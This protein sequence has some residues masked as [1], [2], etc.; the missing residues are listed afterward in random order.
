MAWGMTRFVVLLGGDLTATSRLASQIQKARIIAADG[1]MAHAEPLGVEPELWVGDF[2]STSED[3]AERHKDV[4]RHA[5]PA[6]KDKT[7]GEIAVDEA[8]KLGAREIVLVGGLGGQTDHAAS[9]LGLILKLGRRRV[10]SFITSGTEEAYPI[11]NGTHHFDLPPG[12]RFSVVPF[13]DLA[14]LD[15]EGVKWPLVNRSVPLGSSL[16]VSN[17]ALGPVTVRLN[18]GYAVALAYPESVA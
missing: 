9:H 2:D 15:L 16:T 12:S 1:G 6:E 11:L 17:V 7:D 14:G 3:L 10:Y 4:T 18:Q 8:I 5:F 13:T